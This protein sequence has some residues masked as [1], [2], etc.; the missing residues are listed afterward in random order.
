MDALDCSNVASVYLE[1]ARCPLAELSWRSGETF[2]QSD[3]NCS[4]YAGE[5]L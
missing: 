4:L 2:S 5:M 1:K 3:T